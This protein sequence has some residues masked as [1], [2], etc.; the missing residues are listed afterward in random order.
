MLFI[1]GEVPPQQPQY[2][3]DF[4]SLGLDRIE[5]VGKNNTRRVITIPFGSELF[6]VVEDL[7][8]GIVDHV[9]EQLEARGVDIESIEPAKTD[10]GY[11]YVFDRLSSSIN[12]VPLSNQPAQ[13]PAMGGGDSYIRG[14]EFREALKKA[15]ERFGLDYD[16]AYNRLSRFFAVQQENPQK[17]LLLNPETLTLAA[18]N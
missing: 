7:P 4:N 11:V 6:A 17:Y 3:N 8:E 1:T 10:D 18:R 5:Q 13:L 15:A 14:D 12:F 16:D 2:P 9:S